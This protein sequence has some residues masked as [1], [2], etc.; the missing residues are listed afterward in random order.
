[1]LL[2][3]ISV[4]QFPHTKEDSSEYTGTN[5]FVP[6]LCRLTSKERKKL[7]ITVTLTIACTFTEDQEYSNKK[8]TRLCCAFLN[9]Q[10]VYVLAFVSTSRAEG[11]TSTSPWCSCS[12]NH[13]QLTDSIDSRITEQWTVADCNTVCVGHAEVHQTS[14]SMAGLAE[15]DL[16]SNS[17]RRP[18]LCS[19]NFLLMS[20]GRLDPLPHRCLVITV[21]EIRGQWECLCVCA[22]CG[23]WRVACG[24]VLCLA[25]KDGFKSGLHAYGMCRRH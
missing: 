12:S 20:V 6:V 1:M 18:L 5:M 3:L 8:N 10:S 15:I 25:A 11:R 21:C 22:R 13:M 24:A 4:P 17:P 14:V 7:I 16:S 2:T 19:N 9:L 23:V